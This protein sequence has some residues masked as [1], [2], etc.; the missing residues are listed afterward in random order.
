[1]EWSKLVSW[2][3]QNF[4]SIKHGICEFDESGIIFIMGYND[5]GKSNML[6]ALDVLLFNSHPKNQLLFITD[7]EDYFRVTAKFSDGVIIL[8]DKYI[9]GQSLYE[10]YKD[11]QCLYST[12]VNGVLTK[13]DSVPE[14]I[15]LYLGLSEELTIRTCYDKQFIVETS[16]SENYRSLS[17][18]LRTEELVRA[19]ELINIDKNKL[20]TDMSSKR[21]FLLV[22][23]EILSRGE[24][25][26]EELVSFMENGDKA[27]DACDVCERELSEIY[28]LGNKASEIHLTPE[29]DSIEAE[30]LSKLS[31]IINISDKIS[32]ICLF[33]EV[34]EVESTAVDLLTQIAGIETELSG[35]VVTPELGVVDYEGVGILENLMG[36]GQ[37]L[38]AI[39]VPPE[40]HTVDDIQ[41]RDIISLM[42]M[43]VLDEIVQPELSVLDD[44]QLADIVQIY[45][46][47]NSLPD[48]TSLDEQIEKLHEEMLS[49]AQQVGSDVIVC[50]ECGYLISDA[51]SHEHV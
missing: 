6:R 34:H 44:S 35:L 47:G 4:A 27:I 20:S 9:N 40:V 10:M 3:V 8:R 14:P 2:E 23:Q 22:H 13:I 5:S 42:E 18:E 51:E 28:I 19:V 11:G 15:S 26:T 25:L 1:M 45:N 43:P 39:R 41:F 12:K 7:G 38:Q 17:S 31:D 29:L 50:P 48:V 30:E 49:L 32:S 24:G 46:L 16:G 36:V 21:N 37:A 33:P